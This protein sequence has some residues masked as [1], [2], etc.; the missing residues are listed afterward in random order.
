MET[1]DSVY[2]LDKK[3]LEISKI[4]ITRINDCGFAEFTVDG[5]KYNY[6]LK[7]SS[8]QTA[9]YVFGNNTGYLVSL[10]YKSIEAIKTFIQSKMR[11]V[12]S[13]IKTLTDKIIDE[14]FD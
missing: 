2:V 3:S 6:W 1:I 12:I 9:H 7:G 14:H 8:I 11:G 4:G 10:D 5:E 13:E